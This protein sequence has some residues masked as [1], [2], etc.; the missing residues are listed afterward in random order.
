LEIRRARVIEIHVMAD[1]SRL[2]LLD[3]QLDVTA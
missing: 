2:G 3:T 1:P